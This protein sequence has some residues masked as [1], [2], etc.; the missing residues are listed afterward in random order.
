MLELIVSMMLVGIMAAIA[1]PRFSTALI[2]KNK[3]G[4]TARKIVTDLRRTRRLA[5]SDAATNTKGF[6]LNML[7]TA[8]EIVDLDT[9]HYGGLTYD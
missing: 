9:K 5:I 6:E 1:V 8:Y 4:T 7:G 2:I 3:A